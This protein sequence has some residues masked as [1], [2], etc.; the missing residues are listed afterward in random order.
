MK[1]AARLFVGVLGVLAL[2]ASQATATDFD[3]TTLGVNNTNLGTSVTTGGVTATGWYDTN[4][5]PSD[6]SY[7]A[8][9]LWL[10]VGGGDNG[11]GVCSPGESCLSGGGDV[12][13]LSQ[14]T[15]N[16]LIR[17]DKGDTTSTWDELWV[18]S[19]DGNGT[20][21]SPE[22]GTLYWSD[23]SDPDGIAGYSSF[24]FAFGDFGGSVEGDLFDI[25]LASATGW[26][27]TAQ[28]LFFVPDGAIG[29]NNDY[30]VWKGVTTAQ[31]EVPEP[32]TLLLLGSGLLG[33]AARARRQK[34]GTPTV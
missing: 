7:S 13:E 24:S 12:N 20:G 22:G 1:Q 25:G 32:A 27:P 31:S 5:D 11:L 30:L 17:L 21:G 23:N 34:K 26:D 15:N 8:T 29:D 9:D 4:G 10:R 19:L 16:E 18:S 14:L 3:F 2:G 33:V 6:P 28:Y